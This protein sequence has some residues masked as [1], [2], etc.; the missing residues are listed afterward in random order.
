MGRNGGQKIPIKSTIALL[1]F[2]ADA[3][4]RGA[5]REYDDGA[6]ATA[7]S[8]QKGPE[9]GFCRLVRGDGRKF[10]TTPAQLANLQQSG[11]VAR[12]GSAYHLTSPGRTTLKRFLSGD[13]SDFGAQH[14]D[15]VEK[16]DVDLGPMTVN[17]S[18]SPLGALARLK[19]RDGRNWFLPDLICA[20]DRLRADF[21]RAHIQS[22]MG[23]RFDNVASRGK[24][25]RSGGV[26]DLTDAALA[27]RQRFEKAL[28]AVGPELAGPLVDVCC[29]L[30]GLETVEMERQWPKRSAKLILRA[31]LEG[32]ARHYAPPQKHRTHNLR[33]WGG[34]DYRPDIS[35]GSDT[36]HP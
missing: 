36:E 8:A 29:Y 7:G 34:A 1:R 32:L 4:P 25:A 22:A 35:S 5:A 11:A 30:K 31:A 14:R 19:Q 3:G 16:S 10:P 9:I 33:S 2:L 23:V 13:M 20:G 28:S 27:A 21:T 12:S 6:V 15:L 24:T 26:A 17:L 18:E